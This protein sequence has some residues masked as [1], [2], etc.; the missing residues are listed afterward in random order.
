[1][2]LYSYKYHFFDAV[3]RPCL[4]AMLENPLSDEFCSAHPYHCAVDSLEKRNLLSLVCLEELIFCTPRC[5]ETKSWEV[6]LC[7]H[8]LACFRV[9]NLRLTSSDFH[10]IQ[11]FELTQA[12]L[13][14]ME[15]CEQPGLHFQLYGLRRGKSSRKRRCPDRLLVEGHKLNTD[16]FRLVT[17]YYT[18][19]D[20]P[21]SSLS[22]TQLL[23]RLVEIRSSYL[24]AYHLN[25]L[26][27]Y[28]SRR[29]HCTRLLGLLYGAVVRDSKR[30]GLVSRQYLRFGHL[31]KVLYRRIMIF[32]LWFIQV[33]LHAFQ[34]TSLYTSYSRELNLKSKMYNMRSRHCNFEAI[35][36]NQ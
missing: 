21:A 2:R 12:F 11:I 5:Y 31:D 29:L 32:N 17:D 26:Q 14:A 30:F 34:D 10:V 20:L 9:G 8:Y 22:C 33:G 28:N 36:E 16:L 24:T 4:L 27:W 23:Q 13:H 15:I 18:Y 1:M 35:N 25:G 3:F 7:N 6:G 19:M